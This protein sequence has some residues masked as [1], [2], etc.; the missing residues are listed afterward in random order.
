MAEP[1]TVPLSPWSVAGLCQQSYQILAI[2]LY[3]C[4]SS[5]LSADVVTL[6]L[7]LISFAAPEIIGKSYY[8]IQGL[9]GLRGKRFTTF[10][11]CP[12]CACLKT[13]EE[14]NVD[15]I[16]RSKAFGKTCGTFMAEPGGSTNNYSPLKA[17]AYNSLSKQLGKFLER[18]G[19][20][21][22]LESRRKRKRMPTVY[23]DVYDGEIWSDFQNVG[24]KPFSRGM[25][26][27][28]SC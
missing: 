12:F 7:P 15:P 2:F 3:V 4:L 13:S 26:T 18:P 5:N 10:A 24:S 22:K 8:V 20:A 9:L 25:A 23:R 27:L 21:S 28:L 17:Y 1:L 11:V 16:C 6:L 19:F 14:L